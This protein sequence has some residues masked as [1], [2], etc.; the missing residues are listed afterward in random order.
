MLGIYALMLAQL[1]CDSLCIR[2]GQ[3][4]MPRQSSLD[5]QPEAFPTTIL[6]SLQHREA[7]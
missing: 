2:S 3:P 1:T 5:L 4:T 6:R 7:E